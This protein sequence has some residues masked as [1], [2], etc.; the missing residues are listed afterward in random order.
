MNH[1]QEGYCSNVRLS[2]KGKNYNFI[3]KILLFLVVFIA[4]ANLALKKYEAF[5]SNLLLVFE[6]LFFTFCPNYFI[7]CLLLISLIFSYAQVLIFFGLK[8]QNYFAQIP[9]FEPVNSKNALIFINSLPLINA[10]HHINDPAPVN[11]PDL[12]KALH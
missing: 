1:S 7:G 8:I 5:N 3:L 6:I 2:E 12:I 11:A 9:E 4:V 10:K